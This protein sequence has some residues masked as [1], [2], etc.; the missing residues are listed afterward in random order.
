M[1]KGRNI[2]LIRVCPTS[3]KQ[4]QNT[5]GSDICL[6]CSIIKIIGLVKIFQFEQ[7]YGNGFFH[8]FIHVL[9]LCC[10]N[11]NIVVRVIAHCVRVGPVWRIHTHFS[12]TAVGDLHG[13][14]RCARCRS[15]AQKHLVWGK[16]HPLWWQ[17]QVSEH[18]KT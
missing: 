10:I 3:V 16:K 6:I 8:V 15:F 12:H 13:Q 14:A 1:S 17:P 9:I 11:D 7:I 2:F 5:Q 4:H 18:K